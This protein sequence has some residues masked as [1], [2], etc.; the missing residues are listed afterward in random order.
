MLRTALRESYTYRRATEVMSSLPLLVQ[1]GGGRGKVSGAQVEMH[2]TAQ[3]FPLDGNDGCVHDAAVPRATRRLVLPALAAVAALFPAHAH[4]AL[5]WSS[6]GE[7]AISVAENSGTNDD[8]ATDAQNDAILVWLQ[9]DPVAGHTRVYAASRGPGQNFGVPTAVSEPDINALNPHVAMNA[10]GD[11]IVTYESER[12]ETGVVHPRTFRDIRYAMRPAGG[13]FGPPGAPMSGGVQHSQSRPAI[14]NQGN[15]I[16]AFVTSGGSFTYPVIHVAERPAGATTDFG[17]TQTLSAY[18]E[19]TA[20]PRIAMDANGNAVVSW[21][22]FF[23][24]SSAPD[25]EPRIQ[26][27]YRPVA[28]SG[29]FGTTQTISLPGTIPN[30]NPL[31]DGNAQHSV[32]AFAPNGDAMVVWDRFDGNGA[33]YRVQAA[34]RPKATGTFGAPIDVS[35]TG[36]QA[37]LPRVAYDPSGGAYVAWMEGTAP[38]G[39][40]IQVAYQPAGGNFGVGIQVSAAGV[41]AHDPRLGIDGQGRPAVLWTADLGGNNQLVQA[42]SAE[43]G[44]T[45]FVPPSNV[46][47]AGELS[48]PVDG[49]PELSVSAGAQAV[50]VW[51]RS[52]GTNLRIQ[53]AFGTPPGQAAPPPP[54][55]PPAP[56]V[57]SAIQPAAP[58]KRGQAVVLTA[59]VSGLVTRLEW[60]FSSASP[61]VIGQVVNGQLQSSV[62]LRPSS[63]N[64]TATVKAVGPGGST[65]YSRSFLAPKVLNDSDTNKVDA[66]LSR[67][68]APPVFAVGDA[69]TLT[70]QSNK[71]GNI[72]IFSDKQ[73]LRG[74]FEPVISLP[75]IPSPER[76]VIEPLAKALG[77]NPTDSPLVQAAVERLDGYV[78]QGKTELNGLWPVVPRGSADVLSFPQASTLTSSSASI[79]VAGAKFGASSKG[80]SLDLDPRKLDIPL[81]DLPKP[82][83]LP[84][85]GGFELVGDWNVDLQRGEATI[86]ASLKLPSFITSAGIQIQNSVT[87]RAT[88]DR[89]IV[90]DVS[91][92]PIKADVGALKVDGF[93]IAYDKPDDIWSGEGRVCLL[94]GVCIDMTP[95]NGGVK[96]KNGQLNFAGASVNFPL[97][98]IPLFTGVNLERIGFGL[99]LDPTRMTGNARIALLKVAKLDGR[100]VVAFPSA[101]TPFF[102]RADEVGGG[103]PAKLYGTAFTRPTIGATAALEVDIPALGELQL[104]TGYFLYQYP[105]YVALG[106]GV[107]IKLFDVVELNGAIAGE[108]NFSDEVAN[109]HGNIS[110]CLLIVHKVCAGAVA[111]VSRGPNS[112]G[113]GGLCIQLGP[114]SVGGGV[115]WAHPTDPII[116][117]FDGCKWSRFKLDV[118]ASRAQAAAGRTIVVKAGQPS[119]AMTIDGQGGAPRVHV[120]GPGGQVLDSTDNGIDTSP[121]GKIRILRF[122]SPAK[123]FTTIGLEN[124]RPGTY[125]VTPQQGS[126]PFATVARAIDLPDAKV[127]G[128]VAGVGSKRVLTYNVRRR[129]GQTVTFKELDKGGTTKV[130]GTV[131][132]PGQ[133]QIRFSPAPGKG[134]RT[135]EAQFELQGMSAERLPVTT[136]RPPAPTLPSPRGLRVKRARTNVT[137]SWKSVAGATL[138]EVGVT[139]KTGFQR[140][141]TTRR[142]HLVVKQVPKSAAGAVTVRAIDRTR[143]SVTAAK[144]LRALAAPTRKF[145]RLGRCTVAKRKITC[146]R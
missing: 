18:S 117:P 41:N 36:F 135:I 97:P 31:P 42:S 144:P 103:F 50:G 26:A 6:P 113:G 16:I 25:I 101:R 47:D 14:D 118:R 140:F 69:P 133:G 53:S 123:S 82:P 109:L 116:W 112:A 37:V 32:P 35:P 62:R 142:Q 138:Y 129:S 87:L 29:L 22:A 83:R 88:P 9:L 93:K 72:T 2:L 54:P 45:A 33:F 105:S 12:L 63:R 136:F 56:P 85:I 68:K 40:R 13:T 55:P 114:L 28:G 3:T 34:L 76:G 78:A 49:V 107:D 52:D 75:D 74:C 104:G 127:S 39:S 81:G 96:V 5:T 143:Q 58:F 131:S 139:S 121:G 124:A 43:A 84:S 102:L 60:T 64:F 46:S 23:N 21:T 8:V 125:T 100:V 11:A 4:A 1:G 24:P 79:E 130:I 7:I 27:A 137:I 77:I 110:G 66:A 51:S 126:V 67:I 92:G 70:G 108:A 111:N 94:T 134:R 132:N 80:F 145:K 115:K 95:P 19:S 86:K 48:D 20:D 17:G 57:P 128:K 98:G 141:T 61:K 15:V 71:C 44:G 89:L 99:G 30:S 120:T 90:D 91:V 38:S 10:R 59:A 122:E 119:P 106:G 65:T 73:Q 146:R